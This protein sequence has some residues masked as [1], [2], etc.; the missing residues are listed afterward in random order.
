MVRL[1]RE[2]LRDVGCLGLVAGRVCEPAYE[3]L[4]MI[5]PYFSTAWGHVWMDR[6]AKA[7]NGMKGV[8]YLKWEAIPEV[9]R[10]AQP[11][12]KGYKRRCNLNEPE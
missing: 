12:M 8:I 3:R 10:L 2:R 9:D 4:G 5:E 6:E 1:P 11:Q 7:E